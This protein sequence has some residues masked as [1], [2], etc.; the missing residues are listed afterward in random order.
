MQ[1]ARSRSRP[2]TVVLSYIPGVGLGPQS[3]LF[4]NFVLKPP[5]RAKL[6]RNGRS[7]TRLSKATNYRVGLFARVPERMACPQDS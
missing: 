7:G 5:P 2:G 1:S 6:S 4:L 3:G